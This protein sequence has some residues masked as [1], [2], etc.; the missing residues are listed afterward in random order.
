MGAWPRLARVLLS[1]CTGTKMGAGKLRW[2]MA[3]C[4]S[5]ATRHERKKEIIIYFL[6]HLRLPV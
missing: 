1:V 3:A 2:V 4:I 5:T 6:Q